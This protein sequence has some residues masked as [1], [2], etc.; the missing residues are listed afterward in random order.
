[1]KCPTCDNEVNEGA[2]FCARCGSIITY[3]TGTNASA[4]S[5][6]PAYR[7]AFE[8][9]KPDGGDWKS[10]LTKTVT[11]K[12]NE[13]AGGSGAVEL[14]YGDFFSSVFKRHDKDEA[15][16]IFVCGTA[17]TTPPISEVST[18]WP[19]PWLYSRVL[20]LMVVCTII[21]A[22]MVMVFGSFI[23]TSCLIFLGALTA[24]LAVTVFFFECNALR[25]ISLLE[26]ATIFLLGGMA[27]I[28]ISLALEA[29]IPMDVTQTTF[30]PALV[31]AVV[32]ELVRVAVISFFLLQLKR[33]N[34]ILSCMLVGAAVGSACAAF[35][36]SGMALKW[37]YLNGI[38]D[39]I[40]LILQNAGLALGNHVAWGAI[41]GG[42]L[43]LASDGRDFT[44]EQAKNPRCLTFL[45][46]PIVLRFLWIYSIPLFSNASSAFGLSSQQAICTAFAWI[47]ISVL[48]NR[49]L[50]QV[51]AMT[52]ARR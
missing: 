10:H 47:V 17:E 31:T 5:S 24:P 40:N 2:Q 48:L 25:N 44:L 11:T 8:E 29:I 18:R 27:V 23:G 20:L 26:V 37:W 52:G 34:Y 6:V 19:R 42:A 45:A 35:S 22:V 3:Q 16:R 41:Q 1:M 50:E 12:V 9:D 15:E 7:G 33:R 14:R 13:V 49:G 36:T 21:S 30:L 43:G 38:E 46:A 32:E 4:A 39:S 51:N 28:I